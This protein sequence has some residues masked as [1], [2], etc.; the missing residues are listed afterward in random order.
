MRR[1]SAASRGLPRITSPTA[2]TESAPMMMAS[3]WVRAT[4][5]LPDDL[6]FVTGSIGLLGTKP[7]WDMMM[8]CDTLLMV[9]SS[10]PYSEF[11]PR[12]GQ[13]KGIQVDID[14]RML[15]IRFPMDVNLVGDAAATLRALLPR[16][17]RKTDR[18]WRAT[19]EEGVAEWWK[20]L[21]ARAMNEAAAQQFKAANPR[22]SRAS[23]S[24]TRS[25]PGC[26]PSPASG[27]TSG[28]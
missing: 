15:S 18:G 21:E 24:S 20:V 16:L 13:A 9:G 1:A 28:R 2:T 3:G 12:E 5:A 25:G 14:G 4:A 23:R 8:N 27:T 7:S 19:I 22:A 10:F 11:L 6:P 17:V 26:R